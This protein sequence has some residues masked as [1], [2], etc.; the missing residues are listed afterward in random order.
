MSHTPVKVA[1]AE[2]SSDLVNKIA[3]HLLQN[4]FD[5]L[6]TQRLMVRFQASASVVKH[7]LQQFE[8]METTAQQRA[9]M[10]LENIE[11]PT[12]KLIF[13]LLRQPHNLIDVRRLMRRY[14]VSSKQVQQALNWI[15]QRVVDGEEV[16]VDESR[17]S[18][19]RC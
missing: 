15:A 13:S 10:L 18:E 1:S 17:V 7:A 6:D 14:R 5:L 8:A 19:Y 11:N 16:W 2:E 12:K 3:H 9:E 4:P